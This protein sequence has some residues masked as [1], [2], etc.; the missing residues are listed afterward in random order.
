[1]TQAYR[2]YEPATQHVG[3]VPPTLPP[4]DDPYL[5]PAPAPR[6]QTSRLAI[7]SLVALALG[8]VG[9][10]CAIVLGLAARREVLGPGSTRTGLGL[11]GAG[12]A[13]GGVMTLAWGGLLGFYLHALEPA[14]S[15]PVAEAGVSQAAPAPTSSEPGVTPAT[16]PPSTPGESV[17]KSTTVRHEGEVTLVHVG[18]SA[19]T[20]AAE[21]AKQQAEAKAAGETLVVMTSRDPCEFCAVL[22]S[23]IHQPVVQT[24]LSKTRLVRV[25]IDTFKDDLD[26]LKM[27]R[28]RFPCFFLIALDYTPKDGIDG[29]EWDD[30]LPQNFA[31]VL[32]AFVRG[33]YSARRQVW[34]PLPGTGVRL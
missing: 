2:P 3:D 16:P 34:R 13:L 11:A 10:V 24:A 25:D 30:D 19:S 23:S 5:V 22:E 6:A 26:E 32:G 9:A 31:P 1:M 8:P 21:L 20:L 4:L 18:V 7:A 14:P 28:D 17:P 27:P 33:R 12:I 29:G 15:E